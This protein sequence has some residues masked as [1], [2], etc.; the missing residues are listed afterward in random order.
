MTPAAGGPGGAAGIGGPEGL[1]TIGAAGGPEIPDSGGEGGVLLARRGLEC[2]LPHPALGSAHEP[3]PEK[4]GAAGAGATR[5]SPASSAPTSDGSKRLRTLL[6]SLE[7]APPAHGSRSGATAHG[8]PAAIESAR[9][10][11]DESSN[12]IARA[13]VLRSAKRMGRITAG[14]L[15]PLSSPWWRSGT[16]RRSGGGR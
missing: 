10:A 9:A 2:G 6:L 11:H 5:V 13:S 3:G 4:S 8:P 15:P 1:G 7:Q 14:S 16:H 12:A